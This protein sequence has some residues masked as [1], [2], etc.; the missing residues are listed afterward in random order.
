MRAYLDM[1]AYLHMRAYIVRLHDYVSSQSD[2]VRL[3]L[4]YTI[5]LKL[6]YTI[7]P[8]LAYTISLQLKRTRRDARQASCL[9]SRDTCE[10]GATTVGT[11]NN[12]HRATKASSPNGSIHAQPTRATA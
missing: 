7:R 2:L 4:T 10:T 6:M 12:Q 9:M 5:S 3:K 8:K 11:P 1:R